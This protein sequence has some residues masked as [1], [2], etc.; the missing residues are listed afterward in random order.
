MAGIAGMVSPIEDILQKSVNICA[1]SDAIRARGSSGAGHFISQH[2][3]FLRRI[4]SINPIL[5]N[6][7]VS[8]LVLDGKTY[9]L[10][11]DGDIYNQ[12]ELCHDINS[13]DL[14]LGSLSCS[15]L[16][17]HAY[18]KWKE[19]F[20]KKLNG[21]FSLALWIQEDD[22]LILARDQLGSKPLYYTI[23][24]TTLIFSSD[25][26]G[27]TC[28]P[29][30]DTSLDVEG[31]SELICLSPRHTPGSGLL[32]GIHQV[33]PGHYLHFSREGLN[34]VRYWKLENPGHE[35]DVVKTIETVRELII[36]SVKRQM[37]S[38]V[39]LCGLLSGGL[40]SSLITAIVAD[41]PMLLNNNIY[42]TWSVDFEKS[43]R[44]A[45]QRINIGESD[46]PWIRWVC[47]RVGTRQ[48]YIMLSS[49]DLTESLIE[50]TEARGIPGLPDYDTSLLLLFREIQKDFS[51][52]LSGDCP[53]EVFGSVNRT[54]EYFSSGRKRLPWTSNLAEKI[55]IFKN[56]VIDSIKPYE[57]IEKCYAEAVADYPKFAD[58]DNS[59]KKDN[60]A[61]WFSLYWNLPCVLEQLD[62][63]S[64]ACGLEVRTPLCD[65]RL[66][67]YF[68]NIPQEMKR[69]NN[70]D[71]GLLKEAMRGYLP[72]DIL[73]RKKNPFPHCH[74][75]EYETAI[76]NMLYETVL[77]PS[78]PVRYL[79]NIKTLESMMKQ[80]QDLSKKYT[81]RSRLYGWIIQLDHFMRK[82]GITA[83]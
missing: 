1:M 81:A 18:T 60:E 27:I 8:E 28:H 50:A 11:L 62:R 10:L 2:A 24:D 29:L 64:M 26:K 23:T 17:I 12:K 6:S 77:D 48:H 46:I 70:S 74:D 71:R 40:Y 55:S 22:V 45:K 19:D 68:W 20:I 69:L 83:F 30:I 31:L 72:N 9:V 58:F 79:L 7:F 25:I 35:D 43:S 4:G 36:D 16:L 80:H 51:I 5:G 63:M 49:T 39:P 66:T 53:D 59:L 65:A 54:N 13:G 38:A 47:R 41:Y 76:K 33:R 75:P 15:E 37:Q 61:Q 21:S 82:N 57:F 78:S 3:A 56:D 52:V 42:N 67:E 73:D 44:M 14:C 34:F 32:K